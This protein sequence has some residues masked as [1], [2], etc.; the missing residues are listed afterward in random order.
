MR[1]LGPRTL[2]ALLAC[3]LMA[4]TPSLS[5]AGGCGVTVCPE[6]DVFGALGVDCIPCGRPTSSGSS[7][8]LT[9]DALWILRAAVGQTITVCSDERFCICDVDCSG[10]ITTADALIALRDAI[11]QSVTLK[12]C[13]PVPSC[14]FPCTSAEIFSRLHSDLDIGWTGLAHDM[15]GVVGPSITVRVKRECS[16]TTA[17]ECEHD[18]DCPGSETCE[19]TCDC[20]GD[21]SCELTG[22]THQ[23]KCRDTLSDCETNADCQASIPC[24]HI[25]GPPLPLASAGTP[26]CVVSVFAEPITGTANSQTGE[27]EISTSLRSRVFFGIALDQPCPRCGAP[28]QNP[29][30]GDTFTCIGGQFPGAS[31][32]VEGVS[33]DFGGTSTDCP[34]EFAANVSG[35]EIAIR[36]NR[37]STDSAAR[38]AKLPCMATGLFAGNPTVPGSNPKCIDKLG[39]GDPVC[40]SNADC[41]RCTEDTTTSCSSN[42]DCTGKGFCTEAPDQPIS[43]GFWCH[44]GFCDH[45][46]MLP[47]FETSDC[48]D[49]QTC[50]AGTGAVITT[51]IGQQRPNDCHDDG[52]VCGADGDEQCATTT[53]TCSNQPYRRC[54]TDQDCETFNAGFCNFEPRPC[55]EPRITRTGVPSPLGTY[56]AFENKTCTT[57]ADCTDD[58]DYCAPDSSR[59]ETVALFCVPAT[60]SAPVNTAGGITGPGAVSLSSF[61]QV[62]RCGDSI[63]G[64][65]EDCDDGNNVNGDGCDDLCQYEVDPL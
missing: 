30:I 62:C 49:G 43:C 50:V 41:K 2:Y 60:R 33:A 63:V 27:G 48:A 22:P 46:P 55:F 31:C 45:N 13:C 28:N 14:D 59:P 11:G 64:C 37:V 56:C 53:S 65:D 42:G 26:V 34:P 25:L 61:I 24:V 10:S 20:N 47:C 32:T 36:F 7:S 44:C 17:E 1:T 5:Q 52:F 9:S 29:G 8:P 15:K 18:D 58:G 38:V 39:A 54:E 16:V 40:A 21:A 6:G 4:G 51:N 12:C 3:L 19:S 23:R 35:P 57:N